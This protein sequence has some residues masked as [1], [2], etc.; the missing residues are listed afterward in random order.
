MV[1]VNPNNPTGLVP[2]ESR[3]DGTEAALRA[4]RGLAIISDEVFSDYGF[5]PEGAGCV[6]GRGNL[7]RRAASA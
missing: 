3:V 2:E 7:R 6:R 1:L 5:A 4:A